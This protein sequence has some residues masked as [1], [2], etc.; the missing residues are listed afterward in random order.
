M[1]DCA[2][3]LN[4]HIVSGDT[5]AINEL[6]PALASASSFHQCVITSCAD[7]D[8]FTLLSLEAI[9]RSIDDKGKEQLTNRTLLKH[10]FVT[11]SMR[12]AIEAKAIEPKAIEA[13]A[14]TPIAAAPDKPANEST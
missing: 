4:Q 11:P 5:A 10:L 7:D 13:V 9:S 3:E 14:A 12:K 1:V 2:V 6:E 8:Q